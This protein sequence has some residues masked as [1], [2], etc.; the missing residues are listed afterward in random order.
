[1]DRDFQNCKIHV[2]EN[3]CPIPLRR[4]SIFA[5]PTCNFKSQ[6]IALSKRIHEKTIPLVTKIFAAGKYF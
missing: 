1:M 6:T 5:N 4:L 2:H 3:L